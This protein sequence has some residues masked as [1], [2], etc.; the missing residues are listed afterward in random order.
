MEYIWVFN[1][2]VRVFCVRDFIGN[3]LLKVVK[4]LEDIV[5]F[6]N[7]VLV[8]VID[9]VNMKVL[10]EEFM[11]EVIFFFKESR[12]VF[13]KYGVMVKNISFYWESKLWNVLYEMVCFYK[14]IIINKI[15]V[16]YNILKKYGLILYNEY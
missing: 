16:V 12:W 11:K 3:V 14:N 4:E 1:I 13:I 15:F 2:K 5:N 6:V 8:L 9:F 10:G 7:C